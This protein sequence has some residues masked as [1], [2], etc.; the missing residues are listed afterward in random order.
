MLA[1]PQFSC[2]L[3][4]S[5]QR[6]NSYILFHAF[7]VFVTSRNSCFTPTGDLLVTDYQFVFIKNMPTQPDKNVGRHVVC[8]YSYTTER[9]EL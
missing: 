7:V 4:C 1:A 2:F 6:L 3:F 8:A 5:L 9:Q